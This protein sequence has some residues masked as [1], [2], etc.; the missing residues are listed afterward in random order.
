MS[1]SHYQSNFSSLYPAAAADVDGRRRKAR[2]IAAVFADICGSW[3]RVKQ[4]TLVDVGAGNGVIDH[5]LAEHF[6]EVLGVD[7]DAGMIALAQQQA[8]L[9]NLRFQLGDAMALPVQDASCDAVLCAHVYEHVPDDEQL[10]REIARVLK[11]GGLCYF[12]AG[13]RYQLM[14]PHY[15]LPLLSVVPKP[16]AHV[17]LRALGRG[18]RYHEAHRSLSQLRSLV[19]GFAVHDYTRRIIEEPQRFHADYLLPPGSLKQS[20]ARA[21]AR[22]GYAVVPTYIWMLEKR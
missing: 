13:N 17:Y 5:C 9:P 3:D 22:F 14:E 1:A 4:L 11:P 2:T 10:M 8:P 15:R 12:A 18:Q 6:G 16:L 19:A 20:A 21:I 7:I